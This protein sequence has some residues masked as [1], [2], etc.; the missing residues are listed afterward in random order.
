MT[1]VITTTY[2]SWAQNV[3]HVE[4]TLEDTVSAALADGHA[5]D[6]DIQGIIAAYREAINKA[7]PDSVAL[8]GNEFYGPALEKDEDFDGFPRDEDGRLDI[9]AI[10]AAIDFWEIVASFDESDDEG[11]EYT[12]PHYPEYDE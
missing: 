2:G 9:N 3:K 6:T 5:G 11:D 4:M 12:G 10:V 1:Y 8:C 7:L